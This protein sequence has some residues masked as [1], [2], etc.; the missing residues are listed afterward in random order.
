MAPDV[1]APDVAGASHMP[2]PPATRHRG[3]GRKRAQLLRQELAHQPAGSATPPDA[4]NIAAIPTRPYRPGDGITSAHHT[5]SLIL[6]PMAPTIHS[7]VQNAHCCGW[8]GFGCARAEIVCAESVE[9]PRAA[10]VRACAR[11]EDACGSGRHGG[12]SSIGSKALH[13]LMNGRR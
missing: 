3:A 8:A 6:A 10:R 11:R 2:H 9:R 1:M 13:H 4:P 12:L 5:T 7:F